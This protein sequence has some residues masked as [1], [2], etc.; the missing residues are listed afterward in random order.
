MSNSDFEIPSA[1]VTDKAYRGQR[2]AKKSTAEITAPAAVVQDTSP[3]ET[4]KPEAKPKYSEEELMDIFDQLIFQGEYTEDISL[5]GKLNARFRTRSADEVREITLEV[6][7]AS[8]STA[9]ISTVNE[10]RSLLNLQYALIGYGAKDLSGMAMD[11]RAK[12]VGRLPAPVLGALMIALSKFDEKVFE[13]C[14][15]GE[16]N[17]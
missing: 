1:A 17:F 13:A 6:D 7:Q 16:A 9:L 3:S 4:A 11:D 12:F 5:R 15:E 2:S 14:K 10:R 8:G